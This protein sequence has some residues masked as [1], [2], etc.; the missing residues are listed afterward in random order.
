[1]APLV[2]SIISNQFD[3]IIA[4]IIGFGFGFVLEQAGFSSTK[5]LVGLFYGYDFTVLRVFFTAGVTA[6]LGVLLL[7]HFGLLDLS[8]IYV[9]PTFMRSAIVGGLVMGAGFVIGGFCPGTSVCAA[10]IGKMDAMLFVIGSVLGVFVFAEAYPLLENFYKADAMGPLKINEQLGMSATLFGFLLTAVALLAFFFTWK[11]EKRVRKV[12]LHTPRVWISRYAV[13]SLVPFIA[14]AVI[15]FVPNKQ[16]MVEHKVMDV[17]NQEKCLT[18]EI[19]ADKLADEIVNHYYQLNIIDVRSKEEYE[20]YHLPLAINIPIE[21]ISDRKWEA[22]FKQKIRT[23]VFYANDEKLAIEA[24]LRAKYAG[25]SKYFILKQS[26]AEFHDLFSNVV[27]PDLATANKHDMDL[28]H[29]RVKAAREMQHLDDALKNL[30]K[31]VTTE[32]KVTKGGCS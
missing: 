25:N 19:D 15:A 23:N 20:K 10:S 3:L 26:A 7:G 27:M 5:K 4:L 24:C 17:K 8:V 29:F 14:L 22:T 12:K 1:M 31:S 30:G 13:A 11:I 6:M 2:P 16:E 32:V 9:N 18:Q 28:Y 21:E